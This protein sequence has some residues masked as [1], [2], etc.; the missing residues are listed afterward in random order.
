MLDGGWSMGNILAAYPQLTHAEV[1][2]VKDPTY[3]SYREKKEV[4]EE[5]RKSRELAAEIAKLRR[6]GHCERCIR[7]VYGC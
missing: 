1:M 3:R 2:R 4:I 7:K 6:E 5:K